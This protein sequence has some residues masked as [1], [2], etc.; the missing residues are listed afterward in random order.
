MSKNIAEELRNL[1]ASLKVEIPK[2]DP[3]QVEHDESG[4]SGQNLLTEEAPLAP[5]SL[6]LTECCYPTGAYDTYRERTFEERLRDAVSMIQDAL[7]EEAYKGIGDDGRVIQ[8]DYSKGENPW[9]DAREVIRKQVTVNS[10]K[11]FLPQVR[12]TL[13]KYL[14]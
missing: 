4:K 14:K 5:P 1:A 13:D 10:L 2:Q 12:A 9:D 7:V 6:L 8:S 11:A 3:I